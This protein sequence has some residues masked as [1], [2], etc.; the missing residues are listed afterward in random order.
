MTIRVKTAI[1]IFLPSLS[2]FICLHGF[3]SLLG[4]LFFLNIQLLLYVQEV[5]T[6]FYSKLPYKMG[7]YFL[8]TQYLQTNTWIQKACWRKFHAQIRNNDQLEIRG[9]LNVRN[10]NWD[11]FKGRQREKLVIQHV[12]HVLSIFVY[13][14][15]LSIDKTLCTPS[16]RGNLQDSISQNRYVSFLFVL[17]R[18]TRIVQTKFDWNW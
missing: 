13:S 16:R 8:D 10:L 7:H 2:L 4:Y 17:P 15:S 18:S 11:I 14:I 3:I 6:H 12:H 9:R 1:N 5:V